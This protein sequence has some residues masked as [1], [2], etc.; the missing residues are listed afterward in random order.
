MGPGIAPEELYAGSDGVPV[1]AHT[2]EPHR[3]KM[4]PRLEIVPQEAEPWPGAVR[5]PEIQVPVLVPIH[6]RHATGI[7]LEVKARDGR[8]VRETLAAAIQETAVALA[9]APGTPLRQELLN[10]FPG[11]HVA[12]ARGIRGAG[13]GFRWRLRRDPPPKEASQVSRV[14]RAGDHSVGDH[15]VLPAVVIDIDE[16]R[17]PRPTPHGDASLEAHVAKCPIT[18]VLEQGVAASVV[19]VGSAGRIGNALLELPLVGDPQAGG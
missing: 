2:D 19:L 15:E 4:I 17:A 10:R 12:A 7:V 9:A 11:S 16:V 3:E 18:G 5:D 6:D 8:D 13:G 14:L 1:T